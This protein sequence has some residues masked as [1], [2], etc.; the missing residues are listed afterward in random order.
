MSKQV[1]IKRRIS[2]IEALT[3][4]KCYSCDEKMDLLVCSLCNEISLNCFYC[5]HDHIIFL[6]A[7]L[8]IIIGEVYANHKEE[9]FK[10]DIKGL[11]SHYENIKL[12]LERHIITCKD[13]MTK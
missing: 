8:D 4:K 7:E 11:V 12:N 9:E 2:I 3:T 6:L 5:L 10:D 1:D 13:C